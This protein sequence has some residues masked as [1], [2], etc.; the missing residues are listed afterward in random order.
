MTTTSWDHASIPLVMHVWGPDPIAITH[1]MQEAGWI[2]RGDPKYL[3]IDHDYDN[4]VTGTSLESALGRATYAVSASYANNVGAVVDLRS[5]SVGFA[6][7]YGTNAVLDTSVADLVARLGSV[8]FELAA[9]PHF[10]RGAWGNIAIDDDAYSA[11]AADLG[12]LGWAV[13]FRGAGHDRLVSRNWLHC[14]AF[15][16]WCGDGDVSLVQFHA[17]DADPMTALEQARLG[18]REFTIRGEGGFVYHPFVYQLDL[19]GAYDGANHTMKVVVRGREVPRTELLEWAAAVKE[20]RFAQPVEHVAFVFPDDPDARAQL[21]LIWRY[22]HQVWTIRDG[23]E[24]RLDQD[25]V[26]PDT[27]PAWARGD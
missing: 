16:L 20:S 26:P 22:G 5:R 17:L 21:P 27:T 2:P 24:V 14:D 12:Q 10:Y 18:H 1:A 7:D 25:Y 8:P 15:K 11:P 13:A 19:Q 4:R 3:Q 23:V 6:V 9:F